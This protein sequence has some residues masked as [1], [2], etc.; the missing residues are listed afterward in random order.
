MSHRMT[1]ACTRHRAEDWV[2]GVEASAHLDG[3]LELY[4]VVLVYDQRYC[5]ACGDVC[6]LVANQALLEPGHHPLHDRAQGFLQALLRLQA[7][8]FA[9]ETSM[10]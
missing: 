8:P 1:I 10:H 2:G 3:R 4:P 6:S 7:H 9:L 5:E